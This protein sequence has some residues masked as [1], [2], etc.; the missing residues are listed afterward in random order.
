MLATATIIMSSHVWDTGMV[1]RL[2]KAW[3]LNQ[4]HLFIGLNPLLFRLKAMVLTT[5][6]YGYSVPAL[7]VSRST[8]TSG[9]APYCLGL[10]Q[11]HSPAY[12]G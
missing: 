3:F 4:A 6:S 1:V 12:T 10:G 9:P 5:R 11:L 8:Q 2:F 7:G